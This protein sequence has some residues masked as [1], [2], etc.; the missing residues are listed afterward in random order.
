MTQR[1]EGSTRQEEKALAQVDPW[2]GDVLG[3]AAYRVSLPEGLAGPGEADAA[4]DAL[5]GLAVGLASAGHVFLQGKADA[6]NPLQ[7][8]VFGSAGFHL[9]DTLC[10]FERSGALPPTAG[11]RFVLRPARAEDRE[12]VMRLAGENIT[13]SRFHQDPEIS[14]EKA[15]RLKAAW[16]GNFFSGRRGDL[17]VVAVSGEAVAGFVQ[18]LYAPDGG[19][20]VDLIAVA[21]GLRGQGAGAGLMAEAQRLC[22]RPVIRAGT[23]LANVP[24]VRFYEGLGFR[25]AAA[26]HVFHRHFHG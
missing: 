12:A 6:G 7:A 18:V 2:L 8:R 4:A 11:D 17:M 22:G 23:Q 15:R 5:R 1:R 9:A 14:P 24:A 16:A 13:R 26:S 19:M 10:L 3:C 21:E 20:V 25:L